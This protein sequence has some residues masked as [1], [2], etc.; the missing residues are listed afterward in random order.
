[1]THLS[2]LLE[3]CLRNFSE[4]AKAPLIAAGTHCKNTQIFSYHLQ[5]GFRFDR[6]QDGLRGKTPQVLPL[7]LNKRYVGHQGGSVC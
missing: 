5:V 2:F 4:K 6:L 1:M 7:F 3:V